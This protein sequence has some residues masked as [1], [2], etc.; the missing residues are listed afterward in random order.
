MNMPEILNEVTG[1]SNELRKSFL[2]YIGFE[3]FW[4]RIHGDPGFFPT[5]CLRQGKMGKRKNFFYSSAQDKGAELGLVFACI[6]NVP[7]FCYFYHK[8]SS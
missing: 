4:K 8:N 7:K 1:L 3:N 2:H 6:S 5:K